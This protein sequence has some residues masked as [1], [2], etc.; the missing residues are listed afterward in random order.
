MRLTETIAFVYTAACVLKWYNT[1]SL[2]N[3]ACNRPLCLCVLD[4][5]LAGKP[6]YREF[7][8]TCGCYEEAHDRNDISLPWQNRKVMAN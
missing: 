1:V 7:K 6:L 3:H 5:L 8:S 2:C 4:N